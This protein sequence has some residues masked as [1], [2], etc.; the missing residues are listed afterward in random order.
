MKVLLV[1]DEP[2]MLLAME[3]MVSKLE[4]VELVGGFRNATEAL[5]FARAKDVDLAILDIMIAEDNGLE[6]ARSLR[7]IHATM[8]IVFTTSHTEFALPAYE[9]YPLDYMVKPISRMRIAQTIARA[10]DKRKAASDASGLPASSAG[11]T[12]APAPA[13]P[14]TPREREVLRGIAAGWSNEEIAD[15]LQISLSTVKVHVRHVFAKL[16]VRNRVRAVA[17]AQQHSLLEE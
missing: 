17:L 11:G 5:A 12:V 10:I 16:E 14:L 9:V 3:R 1:D 8:D 15:R 7:S 4:G 13:A 6:L 2:A